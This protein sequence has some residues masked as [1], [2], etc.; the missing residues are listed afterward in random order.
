MH[1]ASRL[2]H[3]EPRHRACLMNRPAELFREGVRLIIGGSLG[4]ACKDITEGQA[5]FVAIEN[6]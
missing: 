4:L 6:V 5:I 2:R 1:V 3:V